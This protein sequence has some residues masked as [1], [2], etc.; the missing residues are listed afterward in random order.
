M[1]YT[2][3]AYGVSGPDASGL[4]GSGVCGGGG[5]DYFPVASVVSQFGG[6]ASFKLPSVQTTLVPYAAAGSYTP[7]YTRASTAYVKDW[8]GLLR[9]SISGES[10]FQGARRVQNFLTFTE[11]FSSPQWSKLNA[12]T[13]VVPVVTDAFGASPEGS[14]TATRIQFNLGATPATAVSRIYQSSGL[15][16]S[17]V[18]GYRNSIW[19]KTNDGTTKTLYLIFNFTIPLITVTPQWQRF[20]TGLS[21][22]SDY[23]QMQF[24]LDGANGTSTS[25]DVLAWHPQ[26]EN[27]S[28][29]SNT[30]PS[31]YVSVGVL[32]AP[33][34]GANVDGVRYFSYQNGNTVASNVVTEGQ[35]AQIASTTL[36]GYVAE[37]A[38]TQILATADI[39]DMTTASW[40]KGATLT[41]AR[42]SVGADGAA[43]SA[44]RLT[45]GA[46][47]ATNTCYITVTAAAS[48]RTYSAWVKRVT[49][50]GPV[51]IVQT[52]TET[53]ISAQLNSSTYTQVQL[54][55][56]VLN[57]AIGFKVDTN[58]DAIDVDFNQFEAGAFA[59][60]PMAATGAARAADVLTYPSAGNVVTLAPYT[61]YVEGS[62]V[63]NSLVQTVIGSNV[64]YTPLLRIIGST[65]NK[66]DFFSDGGTNWAT[67]FA[68]LTANAVHKIAASMDGTNINICS[69]GTAGASAA[70]GVA[71]AEISYV[72]IG[73]HSGSWPLF[74]TI[75][76]VK[77]YPTAL[78]AAQL[79]SMT[80]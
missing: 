57:A 6:F 37:G 19:L 21:P 47:A 38:G 8:E 50:T 20:S 5:S 39:R 72:S 35:G 24:G 1:A 59:T 56:S 13:G 49:G 33:Y 58:L 48:S 40:T 60:S 2:L 32:S 69:D 44:T 16:V 65:A 15:A 12:G 73:V 67:G 68:Q 78:S 63:Y 10:R 18:G 71:Q 30:A 77:I 54:N 61:I 22:S 23:C 36:L 34:N 79:Q 7:T 70:R 52:G 51:R 42:T 26:I 62:T 28:G 76:N 27:V 41:R 9:Q 55:A 43:N 64:N 3:G 45:G 46:V 53:D 80:A 31:E 4:G 25:A 75:R 11:A 14:L 29:Q 74:G 17:T 66:P